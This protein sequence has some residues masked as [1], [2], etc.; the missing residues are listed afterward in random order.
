MTDDILL[1]SKRLMPAQ[2][3]ASPFILPSEQFREQNSPPPDDQAKP[4][5]TKESKE[6]NEP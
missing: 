6:R 4:K 3:S 5:Q 1:I 2:E